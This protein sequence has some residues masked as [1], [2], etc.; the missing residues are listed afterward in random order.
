MASIRWLVRAV[1][2]FLSLV[3]LPQITASVSR[4]RRHVEQL[5]ELIECQ[6]GRRAIDYI[7]YGCWCGIGGSADPLDDT[8]QC[9]RNHDLCYDALYDA[10]ICDGM[11]M[12]TVH[13][14]FNNSEIC[15]RQSPLNCSPENDACALG[16]C[17]CDETVSNCFRR[18]KFND[19]Y[20][21]YSR[22]FG[23]ST[24]QYLCSWFGC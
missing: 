7:S 13:Y 22:Y 18:S 9:C 2:V 12:Y 20:D 16:L 1:L 8:D 4:R 3:S 11:K 21:K 15:P 23:C 17:T 10:G 24:R 19:E 14:T 6:T 5:G